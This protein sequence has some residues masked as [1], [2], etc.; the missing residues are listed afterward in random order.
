MKHE[1]KELREKRNLKQYYESVLIEL[2][3]ES[4]TMD[5]VREQIDKSI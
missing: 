1:I 3:S 5:E 2:I 4:K